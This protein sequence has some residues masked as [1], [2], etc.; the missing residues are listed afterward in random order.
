MRMAKLRDFSRAH[1]LGSLTDHMAPSA[2]WR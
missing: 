1:V 2:H